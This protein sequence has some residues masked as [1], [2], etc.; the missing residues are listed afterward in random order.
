[1]MQ[2][3]IVSRAI[4]CSAL[5]L[6]ATLATPAFPQHPSTLTAFHS[7]DELRQFLRKHRPPRRRMLNEAVAEAAPASQG[8]DNAPVVTAQKAASAGITNNQEAGVDEGDI[9]KMHGDIMVILRRGRLFAVSLAHGGMMPVDAI[10]AYAPGV[11]ARADWYDEML[12]AGNRI[13][14]IGYSYA[15]GGTEIKRFRISNDDRLS[16]EDSYQLR[17]NDYYSSRNYAS[18]LIGEKLISIRRSM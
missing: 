17:S 7:Y 18:R 5:A 9:V 14:V 3:R 2:H 10:D 11:D 16:F 15:R 8:A 13:V 4:F 1:M 6:S 12:I